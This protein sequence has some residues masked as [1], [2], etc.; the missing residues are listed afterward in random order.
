[1]EHLLSGGGGLNVRWPVIP[2]NDFAVFFAHTSNF[3]MKLFYSTVVV[4][5]PLQFAGAKNSENGWCK[6][7]SYFANLIFSYSPLKLECESMSQMQD[8]LNKVVHVLM[9]DYGK[10]E[11]T[12]LSL[13]VPYQSKIYSRRFTPKGRVSSSNTT[14]N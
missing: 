12:L 14:R 10:C 6:V 13:T 7:S 4:V 9:S 3:M 1:M 8:E 2:R 11:V 5:P